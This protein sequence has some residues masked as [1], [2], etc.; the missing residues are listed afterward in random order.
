LS[1]S[2]CGSAECTSHGTANGYIWAAVDSTQVPI[3][4]AG[5]E[6]LS[7]LA[8][9]FG[10]AFVN[11]PMMCWPM[12]ESRDRTEQF[13]TCFAYFLELALGLGL[14]VEAGKANGA[15]VWIPPGRL[16]VWAGH[17]WNQARIHALTDDG[18]SRYDAFWRWVDA[19]SPREKLWQLDSIAVDPSLQG[20]GI[21]GTL[22]QAGL[23][24]ARTDGVGVFLS[25]GTER[26]VSIYRRY[27][28]RMVESANA[29]GGGP[30]V[31]FMRW[32]P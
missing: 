18:G 23:A 24:R 13:T 12:G 15:A 14:V 17:P 16:E 10:R 30:L 7:V 29:P 8:S 32:D 25:T 26:N 31:W 28:F 5:R 11:E 20:R 27:G 22:I 3:S 19:H 2:K 6:R 9:L 21:G 4:S 1:E